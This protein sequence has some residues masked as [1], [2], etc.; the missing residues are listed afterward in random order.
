MVAD[1]DARQFYDA[2]ADRYDLIYSDWRASIR[3][4]GAEV[5]KLISDLRGEGHHSV[6]D[7]SC[8]IGTQAIGLALEGYTV[9]ATDISTK[10]VQR[11]AEEA[12]KLDANL[13]FGTA[14]FRT[15]DRQ[16]AGT[17]DVVISFDNSLSHL[18]TEAD[19]KQA[20]TSMKAK[21]RPD[22]LLLISLRN[23][24][25]ILTDR[26]TATLPR[27]VDAGGHRRLYFQTWE[28]QGDAP[29]YTTDFFILNEAD[30]G[31]EVTTART[32]FHAL[33]KATILDLVEQ[34]GFKDII[35]HPPSDSTYYQPVIS[36]RNTS[37]GPPQKKGA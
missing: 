1:D 15:L 28:W 8:G 35:W 2:L 13:T 6:L 9:H 4:Q 11:A 21:L 27:L 3:R 36:A 16:V 10:A 30:N 24:D 22:G 25:K 17:F 37:H 26:P 20:L 32:T 29:I 19:L 7:C 18:L 34:S 31:W 12:A 23:Y 14:D 5:G 33:T